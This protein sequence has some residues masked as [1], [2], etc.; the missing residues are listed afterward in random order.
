MAILKASHSA[1]SLRLKA[2][3]Q[4]A[5]GAVIQP[6]VRLFDLLGYCLV[7]VVA[8]VVMLYH[9]GVDSMWFD[10][11]NT[12]SL[13]YQRWSTFW[14]EHHSNMLLY[15][16]FQRVWVVVLRTM[17]IA[18]SP[19]ALRLPS[20]AAMALAAIFTVAIGAQLWSIATGTLAGLVFSFNGL[21]VQQ[22]QL[23]RGYAFETLGVCLGFYALAK[24]ATEPNRRRWAYVY[25][26]VAVVA[27]YSDL[28]ALFVVAAQLCATAF[29][30]ASPTAAGDFS[31]QTLKRRSNDLL[32]CGVIAAIALTFLLA[33]SIDH[34]S[35]I[36]WVKAANFQ[37]LLQFVQS[38]TEHD[39]A[40]TL[41]LLLALGF[42]VVVAVRRHRT[43]EILLLFT[44]LGPIAVQ[45]LLTQPFLNL[46]LFYPRYLVDTVPFLALLAALGVQS[47]PLKASRGAA[48]VALGL[49]LLVPLPRYYPFSEHQPFAEITNWMAARFEP[50]DGVVCRPDNRRCGIP[51][52]FYLSHLAP[53]DVR[54]P[55]YFAGMYKWGTFRS[56]LTSP[57]NLRLYLARHP[58][59]FVVTV[60]PI[61]GNPGS[62]HDSVF[63]TLAHARYRRAGYFRL[64]AHGA[65]GDVAVSEYTTTQGGAPDTSQ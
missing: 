9:A 18:P 16:L 20:I 32:V 13:A 54:F 34:K 28:T 33:D 4:S 47:L 60:A 64:S 17:G 59:V 63:R 61:G 45:L 41:A 58:T 52:E 56:T 19:L 21:V 10:E 11:T 57:F 55:G 12:L 27:I 30:F 7:A 38:Q 8:T 51:V 40:A 46:H 15:E 22:A 36:G 53:S 44:A 62:V 43:L 3:L 48:G 50:G 29:V 14:T 49:I 6:R 31:I 25:T 2:A 65:R 24:F 23:A 37:T 1:A 35:A 39:A 42:G 26:V 5:R